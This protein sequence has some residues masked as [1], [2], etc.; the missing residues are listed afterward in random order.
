M[1]WPDQ[2]NMKASGKMTHVT[3]GTFYYV[4]GDKYVGDWKDDVQHGKGIYYFHSGDRY[5]GDYVNGERTGQGIYIHKNG[6]KY[7]GQ[8]K[9]G[10]Q[11]G[12]EPLHGP[13]VLCM[14]GSG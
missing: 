11:H 13:T 12:P 4:N 3:E 10:E 2:S 9:N 6:D 1:V 14:K 8:F 5:E 7:V